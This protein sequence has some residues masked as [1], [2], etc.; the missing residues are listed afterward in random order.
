MCVS[1]QWGLAH[2]RITYGENRHELN[3]PVNTL[4]REE[5]ELWWPVTGVK[6]KKKPVEYLGQEWSNGRNDE[7]RAF[8]MIHEGGDDSSF[9]VPRSLWSP[10]QMTFIK[11]WTAGVR[12]PRLKTRNEN[13]TWEGEKDRVESERSKDFSHLLLQYDDE[14]F[15]E[16]QRPEAVLVAR[17]I[18]GFLKV[19]QMNLKTTF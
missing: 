1:F 6:Q 5:G 15:G 17:R 11:G 16:V 2:H 7:Y 13:K 18:C 9:L 4:A 12:F 3:S 19:W 8:V 14:S 10:K